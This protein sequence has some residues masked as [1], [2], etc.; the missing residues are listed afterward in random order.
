MAGARNFLA[1]NQAV[2]NAQGAS[3]YVLGWIAQLLSITAGAYAANSWPGKTL[4]WVFE[5]FPAWVIP[6]TLFIGF[7]VWAIDI[8]SDLTPN[9]PAI[10]YGFL[11][12]ILAASSDANGTLADRVRDW[13]SVLQDSVGGQIAPWVGNVGAGAL[14]IAFMATAVVVGRRVLQKQRAGGGGGQR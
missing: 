10:T 5:L 1:Q 4:R 13:S 9:Q 8:I 12:P 14:S 7:I 3:I 2:Q 11:G 6:L